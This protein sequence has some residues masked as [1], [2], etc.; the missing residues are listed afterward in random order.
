MKRSLF[1]LLFLAIVPHH[2]GVGQENQNADAE[3]VIQMAID[4]PLFQE[5][6]ENNEII[7][8]DL[9]WY[10]NMAIRDN[11]VIPTDLNLYARGEKIIFLK[12]M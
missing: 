7:E 5:H 6:L 4:F 1:H 10:I 12:E 9:R 3:T 11:G 8:K 2:I